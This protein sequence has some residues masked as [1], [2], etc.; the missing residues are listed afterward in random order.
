MTANDGVIP[1]TD[2]V[3]ES[4]NGEKTCFFFFFWGGGQMFFGIFYLEILL[5]KMTFRAFL[6]Q[7]F[8]PP[9]LFQCYF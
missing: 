1:R 7:N 8:G 2:S 9:N 3:F 4:P 5:N 6:S